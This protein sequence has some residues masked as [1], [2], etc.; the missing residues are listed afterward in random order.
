MKNQNDIKLSVRNLIEFLLRSGNL[1]SRFRGSSRAIAGTK[2]H[3][4]VQKESALN[5]QIGR[6]H[7]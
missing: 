2:A 7:V 6:A 4:K 5:Y 1:D 3:Q